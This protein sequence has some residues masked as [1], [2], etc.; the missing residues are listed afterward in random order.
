MK[1]LD[2]VLQALMKSKVEVVAQKATKEEQEDF[3]EALIENKRNKIVQEIREEYK[4]EIIEE[5]KQEIQQNVFRQKLED[6]KE[7]MM[8]GFILAFIVGLAV[9]QVT[10]IISFFKGASSI[11]D[12]TSTIIITVVLLG[13]CLLF[14]GYSFLKKAVEMLDK[15]K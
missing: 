11:Q 1:E 10:D 14:Y 3:V 15:N 4:A 13:V 7:L 6:L 2:K 5:A 8:S 12:I 9:N